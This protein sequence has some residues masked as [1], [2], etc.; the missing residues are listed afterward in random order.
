MPSFDDYSDEELGRMLRQ[1]LSETGHANI[2]RHTTRQS[3]CIWLRVAGLGRIA[4]LIDA[5]AWVW[6]RIKS[7]WR[8]IFG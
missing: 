1:F 5:A 2:E 8:S 3:F 7:I 4:D 6:D